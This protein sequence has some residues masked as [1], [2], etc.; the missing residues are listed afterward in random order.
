MSKSHAKDNHIKRSVWFVLFPIKIYYKYMVLAP[1]DKSDVCVK[2][3]GW[4]HIWQNRL[5]YTG[6][7]E[8]I[9][10][11]LS[12]QHLFHIICH[13]PTWTKSLNILKMTEF[14]PAWISQYNHNK[15]TSYLALIIH[16]FNP[17]IWQNIQPA[18]TPKPIITSIMSMSNFIT[19]IINR[20]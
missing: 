15:I 17:K 7:N 19:I 14:I 1:H 10:T 18:Y 6:P 12:S 9:A 4:L 8:T 13:C 11:K 3:E 16:F 20:T 5:F 2:K